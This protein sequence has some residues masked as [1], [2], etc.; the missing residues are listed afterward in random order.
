MSI[1]LVCHLATAFHVESCAVLS[2]S[3]ELP[4]SACATSP[5]TLEVTNKF[6]K[7]NLHIVEYA[8]MHNSHLDLY[9]IAILEKNW[10]LYGYPKKKKKK[11]KTRQLW[12]MKNPFSILEREYLQKSF[13][14]FLFAAP[15]AFEI[16]R[17]SKF[18]IEIHPVT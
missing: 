14:F 3:V 6:C 18:F 11:K 10:L 9:L 16:S 12:G 5:Y 4:D 8:S 2:N 1:S 7:N 15:S 13:F 17:T